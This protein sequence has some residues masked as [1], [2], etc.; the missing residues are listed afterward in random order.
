MFEP[1]TKV[2]YSS[3]SFTVLGAAAEAVTGRSFQKLSADFFSKHGI[4]GFSLDDPLA[5]VP[6]R[7]RGY[8][9]DPK[10]QDRIQRWPRHDAGIL[11]GNER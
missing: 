8:L 10:Q 5:I 1:G 2:E 6:K 4:S 11:K 3:L 7:V 9:V